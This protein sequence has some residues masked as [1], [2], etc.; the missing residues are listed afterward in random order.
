M[1]G[2]GFLFEFLHHINQTVIRRIDIRI[3]DLKTIPGTDNLCIVSGPGE[4]G[5]D[6]VRCKILS[7]IDDQVLLRNGPADSSI[8]EYP[9]PLRGEFFLP[10]R[11]RTRNRC[12]RKL[13]ASKD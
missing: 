3:V 5:L 6:F 2:D 9:A 1:R 4:D 13:A 11:H 12:C 8:P 7:F 10:K